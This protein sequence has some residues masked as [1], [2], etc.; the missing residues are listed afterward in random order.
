MKKLF[1][2][3]F[4]IVLGLFIISSFGVKADGPVLKSID[5]A[6]IRTKTEESKQGLRFYA[7]LND[8]ALEHG[9][10]VA[11]GKAS[12]EELKTALNDEVPK[13]NGKVVHKTSVPGI[14]N[15]N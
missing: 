6:S 13:L 12:V 1:R 3:L 7:E 8:E 9:F 11:F 2:G 10:Y 15:K 5:G 14:N 4:A